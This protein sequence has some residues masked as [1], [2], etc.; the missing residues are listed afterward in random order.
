MVSTSIFLATILF[1][2][3][4]G[5]EPEARAVAY[6]VR[7]VPRWSPENK[8]FSCHNNGDAARALFTARHQGFEVPDSA[9]R[10][11]IDWLTKPDGW[12]HNGGEGEFSDKRLAR[13]QFAAALR[14]A[15][16]TEIVKDRRP[17]K[18]AAEQVA[19]DQQ[20]DGSWPS[21]TSG[22]VGSPVTYGRVLATL[23]TR[24]TLRLAEADAFRSQIQRADQWL[25][26]VE[27][28]NVLDAAAVVLAGD[29]EKDR[30]GIEQRQLALTLLRK[31]KSSDGGWGPYTS[32]PPEV[33]DTAIV[34]LALVRVKGQPDV[35]SMID[36]GRAFLVASQLRD[37]SWPETTRPPGA[38]SYA[39]RISTTGWATLALLATRAESRQCQT[40][41]S[42][43]D[44]DTQP[45]DTSDYFDRSTSVAAFESISSSRP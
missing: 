38:E 29:G 10:D 18:Q 5:Q 30:D 37:G 20:E 36:R 9:L 17:L 23:Q 16:E 27:P 1:Q 32:A 4:D 42:R 45:L 41:A 44:R 12:E 2:Q 7:E 39:Q 40:E 43:F 13:I 24:N 34:L 21:D 11:T 35:R 6:L 22:N 14:T 19:R 33:F 26:R 31:G 8:C 3:P 15:I 28:K 25:R